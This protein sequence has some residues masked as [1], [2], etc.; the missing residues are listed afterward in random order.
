MSQSLERTRPDLE[1]RPDDKNEAPAHHTDPHGQTWNYERYAMM[2]K[3][4][5]EDEV[6][7]VLILASQN[8][9][10]AQAAICSCYDDKVWKEA[11]RVVDFSHCIS[12]VNYIL[13]QKYRSSCGCHEDDS[14]HEAEGDIRDIL[15]TIETEVGLSL[16]HI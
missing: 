15:D 1:H 10:Y 13:D 9:P 6:R 11:A 3:A 7:H 12:E 16:I 5:P 2:V 8:S 4:M 14:T